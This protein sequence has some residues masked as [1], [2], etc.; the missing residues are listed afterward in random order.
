MLVKLT[1]FFASECCTRF[2]VPPLANA[3]GLCVFDLQNKEAMSGSG[4]GGSWLCG[5]SRPTTAYSN[6]GYPYYLTNTAQNS[7]TKQ[8]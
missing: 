4:T 6:Y 1:R 8:E 2:Q 7:G 3:C 5:L